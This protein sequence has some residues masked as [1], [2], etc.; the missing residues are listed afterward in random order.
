MQ[1]TMIIGNLTH[2]PERRTT[3]NGVDVCSFSV[4]V[5]RRVG[6]EKVTD[7][8]RVSAWR[9]LAATCCQ[10]LA[11][12]RKVFVSGE[13]APRLYDGKDGEKRLSL[14]LNADTVE[15][16]TPKNEQGEPAEQGTEPVPDENGM[17]DVSEDEIP[18]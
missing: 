11:K 13:L 18:F 3:A 9:G 2:N 16:L 8:Y 5:N 15:F 7:Y 1:K 6:Q 17:F 4:A 14:D 10:Y 12:G